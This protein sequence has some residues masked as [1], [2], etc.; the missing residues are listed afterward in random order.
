MMEGRNMLRVFIVFIALTGL[1]AGQVVKYTPGHDELKY[2]FGGHP[3]VLR[4]KPG[5]V[6]ETW[7]ED[8]FD[9]SVKKPTDLPTMVAPIG[10]DN[11]QTGPFYIEGAKAGDVL[12]VHI[13][14]LRPAKATAVS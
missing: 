7:T 4:L 1:A 8:C 14:D 10:K 2:T 12:A 9:G 6:L 13:L 5:S 11:P 3:A